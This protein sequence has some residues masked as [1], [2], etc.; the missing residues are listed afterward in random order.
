VN[1]H[2]QRNAA[3]ISL[4]YGPYSHVALSSK[5]FVIFFCGTA[6]IPNVAL[7]DG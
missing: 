3:A 7:A 2:K 4:Q 1:A 6:S 5:P